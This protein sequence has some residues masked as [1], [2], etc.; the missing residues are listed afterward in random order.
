[1]HFAGKIL[2]AVLLAGAA[3]G[4]KTVAKTEP[5]G[6]FVS[7]GLA[8]DGACVYRTVSVFDRELGYEVPVTQRFCGGRLQIAR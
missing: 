2:V 7:T 5:G 4:C 3:A 1:M 6:D 8:S